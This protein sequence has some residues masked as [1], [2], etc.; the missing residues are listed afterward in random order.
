MPTRETVGAI[1]QPFNSVSGSDDGLEFIRCVGGRQ[2]QIHE[3]W[4]FGD[5]G[6][7]HEF[8]FFVPVHIG[9]FSGDCFGTNY[10]AEN[11]QRLPMYGLK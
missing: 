6:I 7:T 10:L 2:P 4:N 11:G 5:D 1:R 9:D 3:V 8:H